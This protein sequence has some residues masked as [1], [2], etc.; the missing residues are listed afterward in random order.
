M[1]GR[2]PKPT[3]LRLIEGNRE[4]RP[5]NEQEP[6]PTKAAP[7]C[8][9]ELR[10]EERRAWK[11]LCTELALMA[12]LST[13]DRAIMTAYCFAWGNFVKA[14]RKLN[15]LEE[16][17]PDPEV[18]PTEKGN[19]IQ[20]PWLGIANRANADLVKYGSFLG[21]DPTSRTRI[22]VETAPTKTLRE[23]LLA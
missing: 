13:A 20:N 15:T 16:D 1:Q 7:K 23:E 3:P 21:L 17:M 22:K 2:K 4:H 14:K 9:R 10:K 12:T 5:I 8:P 19:L 6:K 18:I 11:Y